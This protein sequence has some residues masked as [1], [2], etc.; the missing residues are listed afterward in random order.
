MKAKAKDNSW[1]N[2]FSL[3][4][5]L[6]KLYNLSGILYSKKAKVNKYFWGTQFQFNFRFNGSII[7]K[8]QLRSEP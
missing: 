1:L 6:C 7:L 8:P 5:L 4:W 3:K 2:Q